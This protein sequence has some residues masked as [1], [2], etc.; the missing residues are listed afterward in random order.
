MWNRLREFENTYDS[1]FWFRYET[2]YY[3]FEFKVFRLEERETH[4]FLLY[5]LFHL[6]PPGAAPRCKLLVWLQRSPENQLPSSSVESRL[7]A[8]FQIPKSSARRFR[9]W[10]HSHPQSISYPVFLLWHLWLSYPP[11]VRV[12]TCT[13]CVHLTNPWTKPKSSQPN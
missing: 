9:T 13:Q 11:R 4:N 3:L 7:T 8:F 6:I 10:R 2:F 1:L 5:W 12:N